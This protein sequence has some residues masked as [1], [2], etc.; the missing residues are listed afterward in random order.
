MLTNIDV[1]NLGCFDDSLYTVEFNKLNVI[2]GP[3]NSG[4]STFF[5]GLN[6]VRT[7][8]FSNLVWETNYYHLQDNYE[9]VYGHD[10]S[11]EIEIMVR[12]QSGPKSVSV[13]LGIKNNG[14]TKNSCLEDNRSLGGVNN[15]EFQKIAQVLWY[16]SPNRS[17]IQ[18]RI[19]VGTGHLPIQSLSPDGNDIIQFLLERWTGQDSNWKEAQEWFHKIDPQM[20][21]LKTPVDENRVGIET[22]R[23]DG[24]RKNSINLSLQGSGMQNIATII[25][26]IIFS[27]KNSTI[28]IEEP[29]N[30]LN[31]RSI[32]TLV[33]L[34]NHAVNDLSKQIII[35][36][37][38]WEILNAYCSDIGAGTDRGTKHIK[39]NA[40]DFKLIVFN[41][42]L[43]NNKIQDYDLQGKKYSD[44]RN[45][46]KQLWG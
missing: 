7:F 30:F 19:P 9:A 34:F 28:I 42:E 29:E 20:S 17:T 12:Y 15:K 43:G 31:S 8:A 23:N 27:P 4:K 11:R 24:K 37:H 18:H 1:R 3:N 10:L 36:T 35:T 39:A 25:A 14:I 46:F 44:V 2:V 40:N 32:E 45:Y 33:D 26:G 16:F 13:N 6:L 41:E 21:V 5:K 22:E 38:S